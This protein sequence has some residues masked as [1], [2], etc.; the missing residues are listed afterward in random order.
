MK[1]LSWKD[2]KRGDTVRK[3][4]LTEMETARIVGGIIT[5]NQLAQE[6]FNHKGDSPQG[7][8][9]ELTRQIIKKGKQLIKRV[10]EL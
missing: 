8:V 2:K 4:K 7:L 6:L 3:G 9:E 1:I 5:I 10:E